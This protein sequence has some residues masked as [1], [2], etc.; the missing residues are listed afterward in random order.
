MF[1]RLCKWH[2]VIDYLPKGKYQQIVHIVDIN[3]GS[4]NSDAIW[5]HFI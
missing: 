3:K 5:E 1:V 2:G 4:T